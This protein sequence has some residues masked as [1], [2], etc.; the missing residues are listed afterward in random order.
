MGQ[1]IRIMVVAALT[2]GTEKIIK[3]IMNS[4]LEAAA[5]TVGVVIIITKAQATKGTIANDSTSRLMAAFILFTLEN[6]NSKLDAIHW[7]IKIFS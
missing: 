4:I 7:I 5:T 3:E 2:K 1:V 6:N